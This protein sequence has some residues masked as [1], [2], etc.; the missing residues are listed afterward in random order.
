MLT[1]KA[2]SKIRETKIRIQSGHPPIQT[3]SMQQQE[4]HKKINQFSNL[5]T[6]RILNFKKVNRTRNRDN[7]HREITSMREQI[8]KAI[9]KR[10][11]FMKAKKYILN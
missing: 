3:Y 5:N 10:K 6:N 9:C 1:L 2:P 11:M 4:P 8:A 7:Y